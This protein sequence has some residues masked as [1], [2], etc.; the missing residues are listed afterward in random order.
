MSE[1]NE[2]IED[3]T[4]NLE[5]PTNDSVPVVNERQ[6]KKYKPRSKVW[7]EF[8]RFTNKEGIERSK[9]KHCGSGDTSVKGK[10]MVPKIF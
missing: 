7:D 2:Y 8:E 5:S 9:S 4:I 3:E 1:T 6:P 10:G